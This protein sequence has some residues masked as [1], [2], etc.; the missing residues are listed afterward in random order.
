MRP[1]H[2][3]VVISHFVGLGCKQELPIAKLHDFTTILHLASTMR[4]NLC[5]FQLSLSLPENILLPMPHISQAIF[6][7]LS[8]FNY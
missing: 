3:L 8:I 6:K 1:S 5:I 4:L 2:D 7:N